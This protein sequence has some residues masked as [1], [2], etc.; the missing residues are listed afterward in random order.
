M[1][2]RRKLLM[3]GI[4]ALAVPG[5]AHA[6]SVSQQIDIDATVDGACG[7]GTPVS[8]EIDVG[9]LSGPDGTLDGSLTGAMVQGNSTIIA[10]AWCNTSHKL[11]MKATPMELQNLPGYAQPSYMARK[12][13]Y[14]ATL[15]GWPSNL[16]VRPHGGTDM[17]FTTVTGARAAPSPG[18]ELQISALE[19]MN[20]SNAEQPDLML[21]VGEYRGTVTITLATNP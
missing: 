15:V 19:T 14:D 11:T 17:A 16:G 2:H 20:Q 5:I 1:F 12:V 9:D 18:L 13:T 10:D 4:A 6:D 8:D 3:A 7:M 21:E